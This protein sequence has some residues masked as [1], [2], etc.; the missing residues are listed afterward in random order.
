MIDFHSHI[1]P[2]LDD[3]I[4]NFEEAVEVIKEAKEAGF[5]KIICTTHNSGYFTSTEEDRIQ[6]IHELEKEELGVELILGSEIYSR[7][8]ILELLENKEASTINNT[9]YILVEIPLHKEY[10]EFKNIIINLV[11]RGY[12]LVLAHPERYSVFQKNP[13]ELE[14]IINSGVY[15]QA[16]YMSIEGFY[17]KE[18]KKLVELLYKHN[19]ITFLGTDVHCTGAY[20]CA[21]PKVSKKI[22]ELVGE[23]K[24]DE[25]SNSNIQLVLEN[26]E[27]E[28]ADYTPIEKTF[29]GK[30][31]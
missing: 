1:L 11:S 3:G 30:F 10:P 4:Q 22:I 9:N 13:K 8:N 18:A 17:G 7:T 21:V 20:Y 29:L 6:K 19:M 2:G 5:E 15:L 28:L 12:K 31:K 23:E 26:K 14:D 25:M 27:V 24:F 16:N